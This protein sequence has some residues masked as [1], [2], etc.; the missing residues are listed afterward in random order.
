[1]TR[2]N[3]L[4]ILEEDMGAD[5]ITFVNNN[6]GVTYLFVR[7]GQSFESAV[8]GILRVCPEL[9]LPRVQDLVRMHCPNIVEMN[10]R[11]GTDQQVPRFEAA[12]AA[13]VVPP[14]QVKTEGGHR[15]PRPPRW[16]RI[17]AVAAPALAGGVLLAQM[18]QPSS[19]RQTVSAPSSPPSA[20]RTRPQPGPTRIP[21]S[22]RL[23]K[24]V[25]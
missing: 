8:K 14:A 12:P 24:A 6:E 21:S 7:P 5:A 15:R 22:R 17:A 11:L 3:E 19:P 13:G 1:M 23:P 18:I 4:R 16:A 10:E 25:G 2:T 20:T 9:T